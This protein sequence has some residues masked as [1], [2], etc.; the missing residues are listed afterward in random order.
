MRRFIIPVMALALISGCHH[1]APTE[2]ID[3]AAAQFFLRLKDAQYD[4]IYDQADENL[5]EQKPK[6]AVVDDLQ[7]LISYGRP[8][9]WHRLS[10]TLG[11]EKGDKRVAVPLYTLK[12]DNIPSEVSLKFIDDDG[13]W[14]LLAFAVTPHP[15]S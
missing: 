2:D 13:E 15:R 9:E 12:T 7:K 3:K 6:A 4:Q 11:T 8:Q 10:M 14:R 1:E 5:K